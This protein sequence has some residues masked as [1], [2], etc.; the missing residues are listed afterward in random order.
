MRRA[1]VLFLAAVAA[2]HACGGG[3]DLPVPTDLSIVTGTD[4]Q[5]AF[6]SGRLP[7]PLAVIARTSDGTVVPRAS[8]EWTLTSGTGAA[9]SDARTLADGSGRAQVEVTLGPTPGEYRIRAALAQSPSVNVTFRAV[10]TTPPTLTAV[11][12]ATFQGGDTVRVRGTL[13]APP[14]RVEFGE[15]VATVLGFGPAGDTA[16]VVV[17]RC[18]PAGAVSVQLA[19]DG[20]RSGALSATYVASTGP[21]QL[22]VG[23]YVTIDPAVLGDCATFPDAGLANVEYLIAPQS[24]TGTAAVAAAYRLRGDSVVVTPTA[25]ERPAVEPTWADRFHEFLRTREGEISRMPAPP[26]APAQAGP[27]A[28]PRVGDRRGFRVCNVITCSVLEDFT[29]IQAEAKY[30]GEHAAIYQDLAAPANGFTQADFDQLG[31]MIDRDLY[32]VVSQAFGVES[33]VDQ[34]GLVIVL[35][36]PVVNQLTPTAE[37]SESFILGFFFGLD[38][39]PRF[40][41]DER[42]NKAE[43]YYAITPDP[44]GSVTCTHSVDRVRRLA[45]INFTHE[46]QHMVSYNQHV[47]LRNSTTETVWL[48][49][50]M[51]HLSE[52]LAGNHFLAQGDQVQFSRF[53]TNDLFNAFLYLKDTGAQFVLFTVGTGRLEERGALW[54]FLRWLVDRHGDG[55]TRRLSETRIVGSENLEAASGEPLTR[56][57]AE[58]FLANWVSDLPNFTAPPRLTYSS[59][60]FRTTYQ[61]LNQ[62]D[63]QTFDRPFPIVPLV[64]MGGTFEATGFLRSGSGAYF[65]VQQVPGQRGFTLTFDNGSGGAIDPAVRPRLNVIR[66]K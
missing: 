19:T 11:E 50:A 4:A 34:D 39:D 28:A 46:L 37:C 27:T 10:A 36:T 35:F 54:L 23:E 9:L 47:L 2:S 26:A 55:L 42:S 24:V 8:I 48:N 18:L 15:A 29:A 45:P 31:R 64:F 17:P 20:W 53:V 61:S 1:L 66:I 7:S 25:R 57:L 13:L 5:Q 51:S 58:W 16:Q 52:E 60:R 6:A 3:V 12:P 32:G 22:A 44:T 49:E 14:L 56:L 62:Q 40:R 33:D 41:Q 38:V 59:W 30:V 21:V 63:P 65:R 43:V